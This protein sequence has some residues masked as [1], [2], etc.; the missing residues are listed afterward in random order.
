MEI[1]KAIIMAGGL[2]TRFRATGF[3]GPKQLFPI[4]NKPVLF[5]Q[6]ESLAAAGV[7]D[8]G[9]L[10]GSSHE[11]IRQF[12]EACKEGDQWGI[13]ITYIEQEAPRGIAQAVY[14][15][16]SFVGED[17]FAVMLG[18]NWLETGIEPYAAYF[19]T[20]APDG[21][22]LLK[23][24]D[25]PEPFGVCAY[26]EHGTLLRIVEKPEDPP[27]RDI[28]TGVYFFSPK[29]FDAIEQIEPS[30]RGEYEITDAINTLISFDP[31]S[32]HTMYLQGAWEDI[33][34]PD[35]VL[36]ANRFAL[37]H[38]TPVVHGSVDPTTVIEGNA[39]IGADTEISAHCRITGPV[40]IGSHCRIDAQTRIGPYTTI[41]NRV[42]IRCADIANSI[43]L[44]GADA[45]GTD[46][47][48]DRI[49]VPS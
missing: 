5:Y 17:S 8:V 46:P 48:R 35:T 31:A 19:K 13:R 41:G 15:C 42:H 28:V 25:N 21:L 29:I 32:V 26:N 39:A 18:D 20:N 45:A 30:P 11:R 6:L 33:G 10:V 40:L 16:R 43:V 2:A 12:Y 7:H 49:I 22:L 27:S 14:R 1:S 34:T 9:I 44:D 23:T 4:A 3:Q 38:L 24:V 36:T 47:I 37:D